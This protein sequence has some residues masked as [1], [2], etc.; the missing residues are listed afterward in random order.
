MICTT[1][2]SF[3]I[4]PSIHPSLGFRKCEGNGKFPSLRLEEN[5]IVP[6]TLFLIQNNSR[7]NIFPVLSRLE[8]SSKF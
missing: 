4:V 1:I 7:K 6:F 3:R 2:V 8:F 5:V